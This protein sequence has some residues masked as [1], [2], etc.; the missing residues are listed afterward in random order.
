MLAI[1]SEC[2]S[3]SSRIAWVTALISP[4]G[5][6]GPLAERALGF[7]FVLRGR[8]RARRLGTRPGSAQ[9]IQDKTAVTGQRRPVA[10]VSW[11]SLMLGR[12][13]A[14]VEGSVD[15]ADCRTR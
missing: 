6:A 15:W 14:M 4:L 7:G 10:S 8:G 3:I 13:I 2:L 11:S 1:S 12:S 9:T 5:S